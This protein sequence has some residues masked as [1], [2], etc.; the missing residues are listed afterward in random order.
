[1]LH[2]LHTNLSSK[3]MIYGANK[4]DIRPHRIFYSRYPVLGDYHGNYRFE[5]D[6]GTSFST[7]EENKTEWM[8]VRWGKR[9]E[10]K[11]KKHWWGKGQKCFKTIIF[12]S[13]WRRIWR[14]IIRFQEDS[15]RGN[16][17]LS[18]RGINIKRGCRQ[19]F[20]Q[21]ERQSHRGYIIRVDGLLR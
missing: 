3:W 5:A 20:D 21:V 17:S 1:M 13:D 15:D 12:S 19:E 4:N 10:I 2:A 14:Y 18:E 8:Q 6:S 9:A 16:V 7:T 11:L